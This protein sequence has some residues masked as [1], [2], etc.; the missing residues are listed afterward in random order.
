MTKKQIEKIEKAYKEKE[1]K[2]K[3]AQLKPKKLKN[4][5]MKEVF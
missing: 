2:K 5:N 3:M 1:V 4:L